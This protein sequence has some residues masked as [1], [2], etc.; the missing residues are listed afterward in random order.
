V[1][2][3]RHLREAEGLSN[4]QIARPRGRSPASIKASFYDPTCEEARAVKARYVGV[5]RGCG[6]YTQ[7]RNGKGDAYRYC[8]RCHPGA[9]EPKWTRELARRPYG[10]ARP[11]EWSNGSRRMTFGR[12]TRARGQPRGAE[13]LVGR[14]EQ[15]ALR[16]VYAIREPVDEISV[17]IAPAPADLERGQDS[18]PTEVEHRRLAQ[19]EQLCDLM[20][21]R[22]PNSA[23]TSID[24]L[25]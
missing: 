4:A 3:A 15:L 16:P 8:K 18:A 23:I 5:C 19:I 22:M 21:W 9:I 24:D 7:S 17:P 14:V 6:A 2:L 1:A 25:P 13:R 11:R 12:Y 20:G 10:G